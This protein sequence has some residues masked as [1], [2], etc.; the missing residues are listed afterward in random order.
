VEVAHAIELSAWL[1]RFYTGK[2]STT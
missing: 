1:L 2:G